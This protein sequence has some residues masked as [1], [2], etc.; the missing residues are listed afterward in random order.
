MREV[1]GWL[2]EEV[3]AEMRN[4]IRKTKPSVCVEIG[5]FAGKSLIN[6]ALAMRD[7]GVG[8]VYGIDPWRKEDVLRGCPPNE[9]KDWWDKIDLDA[10]HYDCMHAIW[11]RELDNVIIIRASSEIAV[12]LF[13]NQSIDI[14]YVDGGHA[15]NIAMQDVTLY[16]QK[17]KNGG[18]IW[19]D[20]TN[21]ESLGKAVRFLDEWCILIKDF[22][23]C[24]LYKKQ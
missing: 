17:V 19:I 5:V 13:A 24:R 20:D 8:L 4:L 10:V 7:N 9:S 6:T 1:T 23:N 18:F 12:W 21:Y 15:E 22:G 16:L 2:T 14:L 3:G 11:D